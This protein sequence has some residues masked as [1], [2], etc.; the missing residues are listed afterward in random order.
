MQSE[1]VTSAGA[2]EAKWAQGENESTF[3]T[4]G[5]GGGVGGGG[6]VRVEICHLPH[7]YCFSFWPPR[8]L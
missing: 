8:Q 1:D 4:V 2:A 7:I 6:E 3:Y 5:G